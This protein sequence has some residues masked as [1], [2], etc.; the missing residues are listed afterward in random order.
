MAKDDETPDPLS[1]VV[2]LRNCT[3]ALESAARGAE[4]NSGELT[5]AGRATVKNVRKAL[6]GVLAQDTD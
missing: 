6:R 4:R 1:T 2:T 3:F 5:E